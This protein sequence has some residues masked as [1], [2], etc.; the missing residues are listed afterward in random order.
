MKSPNPFKQLDKDLDKLLFSKEPKT[1]IKKSKAVKARINPIWDWEAETDKLAQLFVKKYFGEA[2]Y[3]WIGNEIG[4]VIE[5]A[6][7][8]FSL[9]RMV[10][11]LRY[12]ASAKKLF[13]YYDL[14][15]EKMFEIP[16]SKPDV[17]FRTYLKMKL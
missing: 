1:R 11:A 9:D 17:N 5:V 12:R 13:A 2:D 10:E 7:Y 4:G 14:E 3:Y 16:E 15:N 8:F 6:D